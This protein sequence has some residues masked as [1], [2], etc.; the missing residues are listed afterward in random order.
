MKY[1]QVVIPRTYNVP[2]G[3]WHVSFLPVWDCNDDTGREWIAEVDVEVRR[4]TTEDTN[5]AD[6]STAT[7]SDHT[8]VDTH[9]FRARLFETKADAAA[10]AKYTV[11]RFSNP[12]PWEAFV[13]T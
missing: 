3:Y 2:V 13:R 11:D 5:L 6:M 12:Q 7:N 1:V 9:D 8:N 10:H 4:V